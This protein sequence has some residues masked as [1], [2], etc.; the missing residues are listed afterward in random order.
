MPSSR[1]LRRVRFLWLSRAWA[2]RRSAHVIFLTAWASNSPIDRS[3]DNPQERTNAANAVCNWQTVSSGFFPPEFLTHPR[4]EQ[5]TDRRDNQV[6]LQSQVTPALVLVQPDLALLVLEATFHPPAREGDQQQSPDAG[7]RR[8]VAHEELDLARVEHVAGHQQVEHRVRQAI[9]PLDREHHVLTFPNHRPLLAVLDPEPLPRLVPQPRVVEQLIDPP[10]RSAAAGQPGDLAAATPA[11]L[12]VGPRDYPRRVEPAGEAPRDLGDVPLLP[13]RQ[14][15]QQFGLAAVPLVERQPVEPD[16]V[17]DS[18]VVE[19]QRDRPLRSIHHVVGD[20]GLA[21][22]VAVGVPALGQEQLAIEQAMEV[23]AGEP[24]VDGDDAILGLAQ[25]AAPLLLHAG[26][27]V[28]LL[29]VAGL[30]EEPDGVGALVLSGAE[31]L[32]SVTHPVLPGQTHLICKF[33]TGKN[34]GIVLSRTLN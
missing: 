18:P 12:G 9:R 28:P 33:L 15:P 29:V 17:G 5:V 3:D 14:G 7:P 19:R 11:V 16:A 24:Q 2:F 20:A 34:L 13:R 31:P 22:T 30:V 25:P 21:A 27:L 23:A 10:G 8:R 32:E 26:G 4:Q 1:S 6:T